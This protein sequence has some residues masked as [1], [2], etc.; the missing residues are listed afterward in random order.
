M[1]K[2]PE[3]VFCSWSG[4]KESALAL[5]RARQSG[6]AVTRLINM[7]TEDGTHSRTHGLEA[8]LLSL[9]AE[10]I[11]IPL[12]QRR[13]TWNG[14]EEE[15]KKALSAFRDEG[16][17]R[18][19]FGDIDMEEHRAWVERVCSEYKLRPSL[20]LWLEKRDDLLSEFINEGFKAVIVTVNRRY[21]DDTWIGREID[22]AF[23]NDLKALGGDVDLCGERGE[24]HS[25]VY[26]GPIFRRPVPLE[27]G[28]IRSTEE[29]FFLDIKALPPREDI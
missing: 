13:T 28:K 8:D 22:G 19:I 9:Q 27:R 21:L 16:I 14:Y 15:F 17:Y 25:F 18:G 26:D 12:V 20:P 23:V 11:G 24:Y 5:H 7:V 29:Y 10:A 3:N 6:F 4:G 2:G 1:T